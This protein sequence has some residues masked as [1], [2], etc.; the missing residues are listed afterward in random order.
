MYPVISVAGKCC[1]MYCADVEPSVLSCTGSLDPG[2]PACRSSYDKDTTPSAQ[3]RTDS[4]A[5]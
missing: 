4:L 5:K 3:V 2:I 1:V